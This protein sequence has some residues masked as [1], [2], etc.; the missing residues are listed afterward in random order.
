MYRVI[1]PE[2]FKNYNGKRVLADNG[3]QGMRA[4]EGMGSTTERQQGNIAQ[5]IY[6]NCQN[7]DN[8]QLDDIIK[9]V[10]LYKS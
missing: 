3:K 7:L 1:K 5:A 4:D 6:E 10:K 9:W 2:D 8:E